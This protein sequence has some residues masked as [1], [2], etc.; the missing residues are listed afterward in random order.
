MVNPNQN[1]DDRAGNEKGTVENQLTWIEEW[2]SVNAKKGKTQ[3][4]A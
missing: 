4:L 3:T 2:G 1:H